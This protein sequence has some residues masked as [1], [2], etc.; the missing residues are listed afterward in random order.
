MAPR[1]R[2]GTIL[3][4]AV[5]PSACSLIGGLDGLTGGGGNDASAEVSVDAPSEG[6]DVGTTDGSN[7]V[8]ESGADATSE[9]QPDSSAADVVQ[10]VTAPDVTESGTVAYFTEVAMDSPQAYWRLDDP[11]GSTTAK[12]VTGNGHDGTYMGGVTLGAAGAIAND[13]DPAASFDGATGWIDVKNAFTFA[14]KVPFSLEAWVKPSTLDSNYHS[15]MSKN[16]SSGPPSEGYLAFLDPTGPFSFQRVDSGT[17]ITA[18]GGTNAAAGTWAHVVVVYDPTAGTI[19]YVNG[20]AGAAQ[21]MDVSLAGATTDFTIGAQNAGTT[22]WW[23]GAID[24][25]AVYDYALSAARIL[26]HYNVGIGQPP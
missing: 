3:V 17:K 14:G 5:T 18:Q 21:A 8:P 12:D 13:A 23:L 10:D 24:E 25:V 20:Q 9:A 19:V 22:A 16:D 1:L 7:P 4:L 11:A 26:A 6:A 15:W 2:L